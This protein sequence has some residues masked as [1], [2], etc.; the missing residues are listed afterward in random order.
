MDSSLL[1]TVY[2]FQYI[3]QK[4]K[5]ATGTRESTL[6]DRLVTSSSRNNARDFRMRKYVTSAIVIDT[7]TESGGDEVTD[8]Q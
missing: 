5:K 6:E 1:K 4:L 2:A 7:Y 3:T 8:R